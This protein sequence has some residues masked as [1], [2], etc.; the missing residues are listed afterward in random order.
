MDCNIKHMHLPMSILTFI[1]TDLFLF[2]CGDSYFMYSA[3]VMGGL[4]NQ[5]VARNTTQLLDQ[6]LQG[7]DSRLRPGFGGKFDRLFLV[8]VTVYLCKYLS[9]L[10]FLSLQMIS[11]I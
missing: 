7:Y 10:L 5:D 9:Y 1:F 11:R 8:S 3:P 2:V 6:L 4:V